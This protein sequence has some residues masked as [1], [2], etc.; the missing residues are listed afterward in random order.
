M[1]RIKELGGEPWDGEADEEPA[2][3]ERGAAG[4]LSSEALSIEEARA[5]TEDIY[6]RCHALVR[7]KLYWARIGPDPAERIHQEVFLSMYREFRSTRLPRNDE[8]LL[9][10][11]TARSICAYFAKCGRDLPI[12]EG[13]EADDLP[14]SQPDPEQKVGDAERR[15]LF[16]VA[17]AKLPVKYRKMIELL[18]M[19]ELTHDQV[20]KMLALPVGTVKTRHKE[21]RARLRSLLENLNKHDLGGA[22]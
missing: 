16:R 7:R 19:T 4:V 14:A 1:D 3:S 21:A 12:A 5:A 22:A 11:I 13:V 15:M 17:L 6:R 18:D 8:A 20:G 9:N 2:C 10:T